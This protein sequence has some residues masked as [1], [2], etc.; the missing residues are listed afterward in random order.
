MFLKTYFKFDILKRVYVFKDIGKHRIRKYNSI[1]VAIK[2]ISRFDFE[3][4]RFNYIYFYDVS[5]FPINSE[6]HHFTTTPSK[7]E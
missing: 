1:P 3:R 7:Q 4:R 2:S 5:G 6:L